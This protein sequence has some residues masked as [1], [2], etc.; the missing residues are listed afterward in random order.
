MHLHNMCPN[1]Q[2]LGLHVRVPAGSQ[3]LKAFQATIAFDAT[4]GKGI[5]ASQLPLPLLPSNAQYIYHDNM[6]FDWGTFGWALKSTA[7]DVGSYKYIVFMN[8]S[9]RGPH[10]PAYWPVCPVAALL[11]MTFAMSSPWPSAFQA[12][13]CPS[14]SGLVPVSALTNGLSSQGYALLL[15]NSLDQQAGCTI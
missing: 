14:L 8:S 12:L 2:C 9:I 7:L 6:C 15:A 4:Q 11:T 13:L 1:G 3:V 5:L 10:L